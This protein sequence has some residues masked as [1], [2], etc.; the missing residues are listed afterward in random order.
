MLDGSSPK[1]FC[2]D[3]ETFEHLCSRGRG[4]G[5]GVMLV[6]VWYKAFCGGSGLFV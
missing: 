6:L 1:A 3:C 4:W 5:E 2:F